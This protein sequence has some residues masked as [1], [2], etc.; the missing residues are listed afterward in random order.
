MADYGPTSTTSTA[1]ES[2][3]AEIFK[4]QKVQDLN[5]SKDSDEGFS[6]SFSP[7][8]ESSMIQEQAIATTLHLWGNNEKEEPYFMTQIAPGNNNMNMHTAFQTSNSR[9]VVQATSVGQVRKPTPALSTYLASNKAIA[10]SL[11][12]S[13]NHSGWA[14]QSHQTH[15]SSWPTNQ[16][17]PIGSANTSTT[18]NGPLR[19]SSTLPL[20]VQVSNAS[21]VFQQQQ[22]QQQQQ[23]QQKNMIPNRSAVLSSQTQTLYQQQQQ[24]QQQQQ[25][26]QQ[27]SALASIHAKNLKNRNFSS[28]LSLG[29]GTSGNNAPPSSLSNLGSGLDTTTV[30]DITHLTNS[31]GNLTT[32]N[33]QNATN[34]HGPAINGFFTNQVETVYLESLSKSLRKY[35]VS[36]C[37]YHQAI[38][39]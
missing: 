19:N 25:I 23:P 31:F 3:N 10:N 32:Q 28:P 38:I 1:F 27:Q 4:D 18:W 24:Q 29:S 11:G 5:E 39:A 8:S 2:F 35:C 16:P 9:R 37:S 26:Q 15:V 22:Q 14:S 36:I 30:D 13:A 7:T 12:V 20:S 17:N 34:H 33:D 21:L 6:S